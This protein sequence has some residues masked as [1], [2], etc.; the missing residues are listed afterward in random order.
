MA[1]RESEVCHVFVSGLTD[2]SRL[3]DD[4]AG[5][6]ALRVV[7]DSMLLW[8][9][10]LVRPSASQRCKGDAVLELQIADSDLGEDVRGHDGMCA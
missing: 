4:E 1:N 3:G 5:R 10:V 7:V 2:R 6:G 8:H 9:P